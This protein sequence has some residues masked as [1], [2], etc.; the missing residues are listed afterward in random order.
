MNLSVHPD[1]PSH[2]SEPSAEKVLMKHILT[3]LLVAVTSLI[4]SFS[5]K[6]A[7]PDPRVIDDK[8]YFFTI[9][10]PNN[11][12]VEQSP[13]IDSNWRLTASPSDKSLQIA[14]YSIKAGGDVDL[15]KLAASDKSLLPN[16]GP[17][18]SERALFR[19][20]R[21]WELGWFGKL[22]LKPTEIEKK[23]QRNQ[24]GKYAIARFTVSGT[25]GYMI[26]AYSNKDSFDSA[27]PIIDSFEAYV[28]S[29]ED[30]KNKWA[31][32]KEDG[33]LRSAL[34]WLGGIAAVL[35]AI[36]V[37][38]LLG[39][40]GQMLRRGIEINRMLGKARSEVARNGG[41]LSPAYHEY[42]RKAARNI[43]VPT[44]SWA[45]VYSVVAALAPVKI[46]LV[47]LALLVVPILGYFGIFFVPSEDPGDYLPG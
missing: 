33:L 2:H 31:K 26:V 3:I 10:T 13:R 20:F 44:L 27:L 46:F 9:E 17:V 45:A 11:W 42:K 15:D 40:S 41:S 28:S 22:F 25:Y 47:S 37:L 36:G 18:V 21:N 8:D 35:A 19:F 39:K 1:A 16:L 43:L 30:I 38:F 14:V 12:Q 7:S 32:A 5:A 29:I 4:L 24:T 34:G 6:A 23:Y